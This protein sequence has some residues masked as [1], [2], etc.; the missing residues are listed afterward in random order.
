MSILTLVVVAIASSALGHYLIKSYFSSV[1]VSTI[2]AA[3]LFQ[4]IDFNVLG[5]YYPFVFVGLRITLGVSCLVSLLLG[6]PFL[7][8]RKTKSPTLQSNIKKTSPK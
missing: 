2:M 5:Y 6:I 3:I 8:R 7:I 1:L 4:I